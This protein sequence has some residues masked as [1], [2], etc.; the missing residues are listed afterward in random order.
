MGHITGRLSLRGR[1]GLGR[2]IGTLLR[3]ASARRAQITLHQIARVFPE[4][5]AEDHARICKESYHNLG[6]V[7]AELVAF[8]HISPDE[9]RA[10]TRYTNRHLFD[11]AHEQGRS[12]V[13]VSAH[14]GNWEVMAAG[15]PLYFSCPT[16]IVVFPQYNQTADAILNRYR[17]QTGNTLVQMSGAAR[18]MMRRLQEH[19]SV[20]ML[21]DQNALP[22]HGLVMDFLGF[23]ASVYHAPASLALRYNS[24]MIVGFCEREDDGTYTSR[25]HEI[26]HSDL[27]FTPEGVRELTR[28]HVALLEAQIRSRP[29]LWSWQHRRWKV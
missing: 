9:M 15:F 14:Y 6:I 21:A 19:G 10:M 5:T 13:L 16:L 28:R 27:S 23:P 18:A 4:R 7:L 20:A 1:Q 22:E 17:S 8:P 29:E 2:M 24:A 11:R 3:K 12:I 25:L 26:D